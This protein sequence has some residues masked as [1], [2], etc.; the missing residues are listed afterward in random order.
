M[1]HLFSDSLISIDLSDAPVSKGH[2]IVS[3][4]RD[5]KNLIDL[6]D[7][8]ISTL[9]FGAS[10]SATALFELIGAHGT[11]IFLTEGNSKLEL[12]VV[13]RKENDGLN[14]LWNPTELS[15]SD[16]DGIFNK[17]KDTVDKLIWERDNPEEAKKAKEVISVKKEEIVEEKGKKNILFNIFNRKP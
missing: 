4:V 6:S 11:N 16:M 5:V 14:M 15:S 12:N 10:Y 7:D 17:L 2:I 3:P 9:F 8:E 1:N 13:A